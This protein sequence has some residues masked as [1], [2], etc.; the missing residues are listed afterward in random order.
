[1]TKTAPLDVMLLATPTRWMPRVWLAPA[2]AV[3]AVVVAQQP[4]AP[5]TL[6]P[7]QAPPQG[8]LAMMGLHAK[9][10]V[11]EEL[12]TKTAPLDVMLLATPTRWM[13]RARLVSLAAVGSQCNQ[14]SHLDRTE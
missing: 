12:W 10:M 8:G 7:Q 14:R 6:T 2:A 5:L 9:K 1:M 3:A 13:P 11:K 4:L